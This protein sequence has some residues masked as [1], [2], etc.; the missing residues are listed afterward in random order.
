MDVL[1]S[2][3]NKTLHYVEID[4]MITLKAENINSNLKN[5]EISR[6]DSSTSSIEFY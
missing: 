6:V 3:E 5:N 2:D 1:Q 4:E